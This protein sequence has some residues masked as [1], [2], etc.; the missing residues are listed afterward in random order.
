[1]QIPY[2]II[3]LHL[4]CIHCVTFSRYWYAHSAL[5]ATYDMVQLDAK[6]KDTVT[7]L[8]THPCFVP[9]IYYI[10]CPVVS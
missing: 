4:Q 6:R 9:C 5:F 8:I 1:M 7:A 2:T 10:T 3:N